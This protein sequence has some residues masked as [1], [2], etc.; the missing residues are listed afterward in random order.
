M[1]TAKNTHVNPQDLKPALETL[2]RFAKQHGAD[3]ADA[4]TAHGRSLSIGVR[5]GKLEDIDNSEGQDIGL[6]VFVGQRQ[7]CVSS[8]D[9]A[10]TSLETLSER[11][12]AMAKLAPEDPYCGLAS[13]SKRANSSQDLD[14]FDPLQINPDEL[15]ERAKQLEQTALSGDNIQQAEGAN[16][17]ASNSAVYFMTSDGFAQGWHAS[18]HGL[19]VSA[20]AAKDG[21]MERDYDYDSS[22]HFADLPTPETIGLKAATRAAARLG[23]KQIKSGTMPVLFERRVATHILSAFINAICGPTIARGGFIFK[24]PYGNASFWG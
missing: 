15:F 3:K 18:Q 24:R 5:E 10:H 17:Y 19:S 22:C 6:R 16:A 21:A 9:L 7:A 1:K 14:I 12:V 11:A 8:S 13:A 23:A 2:L 4:I 20:I